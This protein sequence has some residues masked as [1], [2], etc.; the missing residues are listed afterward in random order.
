MTK[1]HNRRRRAL[2]SVAVFIALSSILAVASVQP[3]AAQQTTF[4]D[5]PTGAYFTTPVN[6]LAAQGVFAGTEC[7]DGFCPSDP[8]LRWQM[9]VWIV[10]VLDGEE[11]SPISNYRFND[12]DAGDWYAPHVEQMYQLGVTTGCGDGSGFCPDRGVSRAEMA[13]FLKRAFKLPDGPDPGFDDVPVGAWYIDSVAALA[14]SEITTGCGDGSGFCP[15]RDTTRAQMATFLHRAINRPPDV[16]D[17]DCDFSDHSD[18]VRSAVYQVRTAEGIGTAFYIGND[19]WLTAAHVVAGASTVTLHN[20]GS[21]LEATILGGS[22]E[23]DMALL[24]APG[25]GIGPL[26]FARLT[27]AKAGDSLFVVGYPLYVAEEPSVAR[28]VL[29][30]TEIDRQLGTLI[31][32]DASANP[33]NSGGPVVDECGRVMGMI[34]SKLVAEDVEGIA[35]AIAETTLQERLPEMHLGGPESIRV[36]RTYEDCFGSEVSE[37]SEWNSEWTDG[38]NG[39]IYEVWRHQSDGRAGGSA[40]LDAVRHELNDHRNTLG[41]G[42]DFTPYLWVSC[43]AYESSEPFWLGI[44]WSGIPTGTAVDNAISVQYRLDNNSRTSMT[45]VAGEDYASL[46]GA[47]AV[48][49]VKQL[50][51]ANKFVFWGYDASGT[52]VI[53]AEFDTAEIADSLEHLRDTCNWN[54]TEPPSVSQP[55]TTGSSVWVP[56]DGENISG[57]YVGVYTGVEISEYDWQDDWLLLYIRCSSRSTLEVFLI[58][59]GGSFFGNGGIVVEYRFGS[60][61]ELT[62]VLANSGTEHDTAFLSDPSSFVRDLRS[63]DS[64][65]LFVNLWDWWTYTYSEDA[66]DFEGGGEMG[67]VGVANDVEPVLSA[68]GY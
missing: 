12:V 43:A 38:P 5:V 21:E 34:V 67:V 40:Y 61:A 65:R 58:V 41:E 15:S 29:S 59:D 54:S 1:Q 6:A 55:Q 14:A 68:C 44:W 49:L 13:V 22:S 23:A 4:D 20:D 39:W 10:R 50:S 60:Q 3:V 46:G 51:N 25:T 24:K 11:P 63:D 33:G 57:G 2:T 64:G 47:S 36:V 8:L 66:F 30:R 62:S 42:C 16:S 18:R 32:T 52:Q 45:W 48:S 26:S 19:V 28:G 27:S 56:F 9:A 17:A 7:S 37:V 35:Y 53:E 31:V